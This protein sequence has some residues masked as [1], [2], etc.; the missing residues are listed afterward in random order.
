[1]GL[2]D[3]PKKC[4]LICANA[5][6]GST[7]LCQSLSDTGIAGHPAEYFMTWP[8]PLPAHSHPDQGYWEHSPLA[9]QHGVTNRD[10]FLRLVYRT[11]CTPNGVFGAK[12]M[13]NYTPWALAS[14]REM[15]HF[16]DM[17]RAEILADAFPGLRVVHLVRRDR[18]RQAVSWLRAAEDGVWKVSDA[19]PAKPSREPN[20]NYGVIKGM[21]SLI[22]QGEQAWIELYAELG[23]APF[24]VV[25]EDLL[26]SEGY[27]KAVRGVLHHLGLNDTGPVPPPRTHRQADH[28]NDDWVERFRLAQANGLA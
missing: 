3:L 4:Y 12:F 13:W 25:Y 20:Y 18:L 15:D 27:E 19:D 2:V 9:R 21:M 6:C 11:G 8:E 5:R 17:G 14:F 7:L 22:S 10:D 16:A 24:E 28:I 1:M 26:T 23:L